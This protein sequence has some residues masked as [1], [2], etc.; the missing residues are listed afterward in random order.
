M[1]AFGPSMP[2][3]YYCVQ[4]RA[5]Y[6]RAYVCGVYGVMCVRV[7]MRGAE[8]VRVVGAIDMLKTISV[9]EVVKEGATSQGIITNIEYRFFIYLFIVYSIFVYYHI[10]VTLVLLLFCHV[11]TINLFYY[12]WSIILVYYFEIIMV[13]LF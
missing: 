1:L 6:V 8:W 2:N 12:F 13:L 11:F 4:F 3:Y 7:S 10:I 9:N 5:F